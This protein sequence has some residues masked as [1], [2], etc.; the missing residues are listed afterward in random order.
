MITKWMVLSEGA[1]IGV[2]QS[3]SFNTDV[4]MSGQTKVKLDLMIRMNPGTDLKELTI[5]CIDE[6][7]ILVSREGRERYKKAREA[8][9]TLVACETCQDTGLVNDRAGAPPGVPCSDYRCPDCVPRP[10]KALSFAEE[11][12]GI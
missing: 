12:K 4:M 6:A 11:L 1:C 10:V 3:V 8:R 7:P 2:V 5:K 9:A